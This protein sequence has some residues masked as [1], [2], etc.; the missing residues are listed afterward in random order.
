MQARKVWEL[1]E[2]RKRG[3]RQKSLGRTITSDQAS[4]SPIMSSSEAGDA[5]RSP[6]VSGDL[7]ARMHGATDRNINLVRSLD[8]LTEDLETEIRTRRREDPLVHVTG[9]LERYLDL[10]DI[11]LKAFRSLGSLRSALAA[12]D[13]ELADLVAVSTTGSSAAATMDR[14]NGHVW[15]SH[16][17]SSYLHVFEK[18]L[19]DMAEAAMTTVNATDSSSTS[20]DQ[21]KARSSLRSR[22]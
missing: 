20:H 10:C 3:K 14:D 4:K 12:F 2:K 11:Y 19:A 6:I 22:I 16:T 9:L 21:D 7:I 17:F 5:R 1:Q 8:M 18:E 13:K 15:S